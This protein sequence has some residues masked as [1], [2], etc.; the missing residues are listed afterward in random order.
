M[1]AVLEQRSERALDQLKKMAA[2]VARLRRECWEILV[3]ASEVVPGD[4][5]LVQEGDVLVAD[6]ELLAGERLSFDE[7]SLT[8]ESAPAIKSADRPKGERLVLAGT[9]LM[10]GHGVVRV[11]TTGA[12]TE[13]G[14][15]GVLMSEI[16]FTRTPIEH[17]IHKIH[18][19]IGIVVIL[20]CIVVIA[21]ERDDGGSM[22]D[23][24]RSAARANRNIWRA[25]RL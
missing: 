9:T 24:V 4:I 10:A 14:R 1:S 6:G 16:H 3:D 13:Y 20:V 18:T 15:I 5:M 25:S 19:Q 17:A 12:K 2:P 8:G 21:V 7:S 23:S 11:T 22:A